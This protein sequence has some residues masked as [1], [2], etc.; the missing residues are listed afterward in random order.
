LQHGPPIQSAKSFEE[1]GGTRTP[2]GRARVSRADGL[3]FGAIA[4]HGSIAAQ[5]PKR[6]VADRMSAAW[7]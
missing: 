5:W 2:C 6:S 4:G 3:F 1:L 7:W